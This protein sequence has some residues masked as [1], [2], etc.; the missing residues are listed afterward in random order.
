MHGAVGAES[1]VVL[2]QQVDT[3]SAEPPPAAD[4]RV[5]DNAAPGRL[6]VVPV[7]QP[8]R[9]GVT[10]LSHATWD[11]TD[12]EL[13][14]RQTEREQAHRERVVRELAAQAE[15]LTEAVKAAQQA[16]GFGPAPPAR[17]RGQR[18]ETVA[19]RKKPPRGRQT[20]R[21]KS[22]VASR[23]DDVDETV[24]DEPLRY[25]ELYAGPDDTADAVALDDADRE[26]LAT[27]DEAEAGRRGG[28]AVADGKTG[29]RRAE[30]RPPRDRP[31]PLAL[32]AHRQHR[33]HNGTRRAAR[34][35]GGGEARETTPGPCDLHELLKSLNIPLALA[36]TG[37]TAG[38]RIRR[39]RVRRRKGPR[40]VEKNAPVVILS[41]RALERLRPAVVPQMPPEAAAARG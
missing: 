32:W 8:V 2:V 28:N 4:A 30:R 23:S 17:T 31:A 39:V 16:G 22:G 13:A 27:A 3:G 10:P 38:C 11:E 5:P 29:R 37:Y 41:R 14:A 20:G 12:R 19:A 35:G 36:E 40:P 1:P 18:E 15:A 6:V 21:S 7:Y 26:G 33:Y 24:P 34:A 9:G 25:D